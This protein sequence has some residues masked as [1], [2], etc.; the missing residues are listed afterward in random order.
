MKMVARAPG[1]SRLTIDGCDSH[2]FPDGHTRFKELMSSVNLFAVMFNSN[3]KLIYCNGHFVRMT[4]LS[5]DEVLGH[6]WDE[7]F[8]SPWEGYL[9][10]PFGEWLN[11]RPEALHHEGEL[12]TQEGERYWVRWNSIPRISRKGER[13]LGRA[14]KGIA[15]PAARTQTIGRHRRTRHEEDL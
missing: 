12:L 11:N 7:I 3:A 8:V 13:P 5:P 4:G 9:P 15:L 1:I 2:A 10:N 6:N 14:G